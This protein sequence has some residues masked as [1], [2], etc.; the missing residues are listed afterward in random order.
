MGEETQEVLVL[1]LGEVL[2]EE[3]RLQE[4]TLHIHQHVKSTVVEVGLPGN[5]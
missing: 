1:G 2:D 3:M 4:D 5:Q